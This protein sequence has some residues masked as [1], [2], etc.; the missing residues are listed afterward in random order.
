MSE[1]P[2]EKVLDDLKKTSEKVDGPLT[3]EEYK[4]HGEYSAWHFQGSDKF[5]NFNSAKDKIGLEY[6]NKNIAEDE[7]KKELTRLKKEHDRITIQVLRKHGKISRGILW[8]K[9]NGLEDACEKLGIEKGEYNS[10]KDYKQWE[11]Y[12]IEEKLYGRYRL[13]DLVK[14][15][16]EGDKNRLGTRHSDFIK[17]INDRD[18][19]LQVSRSSGSG[20][21]GCRAV[22]IKNEN[23]DRHDKWRD[24]L[25]HDQIEVFD[26]ALNIGLAPKSIVAVLKYIDGDKTQKEVSEK[27]GC[28]TVTIRNARD[29]MLEEDLISI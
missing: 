9:F 27:I 25:T 29:R 28:S 20:S 11:N 13:K 4:K 14:E 15:L 22:F 24:M 23:F 6:A 1:V 19:N 5:D 7:I 3:L 12:I 2:K 18:N 10:E 26:E 16:T 8:S 17:W 21:Y